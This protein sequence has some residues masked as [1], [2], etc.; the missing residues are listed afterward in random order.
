[1]QQEYRYWGM[2]SN[3]NNKHWI[4]DIISNHIDSHWIFDAI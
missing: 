4:F 1:M 2:S 3:H